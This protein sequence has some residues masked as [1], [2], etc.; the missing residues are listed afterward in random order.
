MEQWTGAVVR[1]CSVKKVFLKISENSQKKTCARVPFSI[2]LQAMPLLFCHKVEAVEYFK[3][4][5]M[6]CGDMNVITR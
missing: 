6:K 4:F 2:K 1:R 3:L 5:G